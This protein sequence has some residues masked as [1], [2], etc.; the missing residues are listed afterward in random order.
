L[1]L[2][3]PQPTQ[4][5]PLIVESISP[6]P[7]E[8]DL[9]IEVASLREQ[10]VQFQFANAMGQVIQSEKRTLKK[11]SNSVQFD[12]WSLP[13]GIY[14]LQTDVNRGRISPTKFVKF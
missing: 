13:Q 5:I 2:S 9:T 11:G 4:F 10:V 12:V 7:T 6:N 8:G 3:R 14:F 1:A